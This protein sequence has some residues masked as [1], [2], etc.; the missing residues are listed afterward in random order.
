[1]NEKISQRELT[2]QPLRLRMGASPLSPSSL[3]LS[4]TQSPKI[5]H[6]ERFS[7]LGW[8]K[9]L[10]FGQVFTIVFTRTCSNRA[11]DARTPPTTCKLGPLHT[12]AKCCDHCES[13]KESVQRPS[14][15][16]SKI[17]YV[18]MDP[19]VHCDVIWGRALNQMLFQ[20]NP[21]HAGPPRTW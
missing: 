5:L 2:R 16:T 9:C 3:R 20:W 6:V 8:I 13:P 10:V 17:T 11:M 15:H 18:V 19:Q 14:Q 12:R 21:S 1:M 7:W 4:R